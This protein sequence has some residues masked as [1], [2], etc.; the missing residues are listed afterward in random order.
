MLAIVRKLGKGTGG[1]HR[2]TYANGARLHCDMMCLGRHW[3]AD[4]GKYE[5]TRSDV[6]GAT[7][8]LI[9]AELLY[10]AQSPPPCRREL[11]DFFPFV[12]H[13]VVVHDVVVVLLRVP[14]LGSASLCWV[15][16]LKF[17]S[18]YPCTSSALTRPPLVS[19]H[20]VWGVVRQGLCS[21]CV[22]GGRTHRR[23]VRGECQGCHEV[24]WVGCQSQHGPDA[25]HS[26]CWPSISRRCT[27][28]PSRCCTV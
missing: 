5:A 27:A 26:A 11:L 17:E 16:C 9:P 24:P 4:E 14:A 23:A 6:D 28:V 12:A 21:P 10:A 19:F 3:N 18:E 1:F 22:H 20:N 13:H 8:P 15:V 7:P 2:P 25:A